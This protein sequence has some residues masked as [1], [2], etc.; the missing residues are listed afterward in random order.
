MERAYVFIA[1]TNT[2][3]HAV[4]KI[5]SAVPLCPPNTKTIRRNAHNAPG[6]QGWCYKEETDSCHGATLLKAEHTP[7]TWWYCCDPQPALLHGALAKSLIL[8]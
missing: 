5:G 4:H 7:N 2:G 6:Q 3:I 8:V 1:V